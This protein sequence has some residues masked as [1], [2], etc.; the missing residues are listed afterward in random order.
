M[1]VGANWRGYW[2]PN[3]DVMEEQY[4]LLTTSQ[5]SNPTWL[6]FCFLL[7]NLFMQLVCVCEAGLEGWPCVSMYMCLCCEYVCVSVLSVHMYVCVCMS[8]YLF[9]HVCVLCEHEH[10]SVCMC[11]CM[12]VSESV[13]ICLYV[14]VLCVCVCRSG[15]NSCESVLFHHMGS[16]IKFRPWWQ[17]PLPSEP[18]H[19]PYSLAFSNTWLEIVC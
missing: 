18:S 3:L 8:L 15:D 2:K 19:W 7:L 4:S 12:C 17:E 9:M 5:L 16:G 1:P 14:C 6:A 11:L 13:C 10:V